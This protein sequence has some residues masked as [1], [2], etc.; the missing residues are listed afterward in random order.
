[1]GL[2]VSIHLRGTGPPERREAA[3][4]A[5]F[6]ELAEVDRVFS[7][8][9][10]DSDISLVRAGMLRIDE[11]EPTVAE[12]LE[13]CAAAESATGGYFTTRLPGPDGVL[14]FD[15]TGLVKGWAVERAAGH[16]DV[17]P[18][19]DYYL[20]AGGDI[21]L[22]VREEAGRPP[23]RVA[24]EDPTCVTGRVAVLELASGGVATSGT[25]RRGPHIID[26]VRGV[27]AREL[28]SVT[29][30]GPSLMWADVFATA[31]CARG[32]DAAELAWPP[33]YHALAVPA[34]GDV[35][36]LTAPASSATVG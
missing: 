10:P 21:A 7:T 27:A 1:M 22:A 36:W 20:N 17:L 6:A 14:R 11:C 28:L 13:L 16:L 30:L 8:Y 35:G 15:P 26:P 33:G 32:R 29:V 23:W 31:A 12:V 3:V 4:E 24:V 9:R 19:D 5:I 34:A 2:P 25:A 18:E